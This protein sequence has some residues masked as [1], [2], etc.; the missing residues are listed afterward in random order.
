MPQYVLTYFDGRGVAETS[1]WLFALA[2]QEYEDKRVTYV[3]G[4]NPEW[5]KLK[6][7][8]PFG[9][10]PMLEVDGVKL[11]QSNAIATFLALEFGFGGKTNLERAR[12]AMILDC[13]VDVGKSVNPIYMEKDETKKAELVTKLSEDIKTHLKNFENFVTENGHSHF[14]GNSITL[15]DVAFTTGMDRLTSLI[16]PH[17]ENYPKLK[18]IVDS[19]TNHPKIAAWIAKRPQSAF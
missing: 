13:L 10:L 8:T 15:A 12:I 1:R 14:V 7:T 18:A 5:L 2:D 11:C 4:E 19:T 3:P 9:Q 16:D 6:P 17:L